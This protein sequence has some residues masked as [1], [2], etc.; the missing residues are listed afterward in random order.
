M[1]IVPPILIS[2]YRCLYLYGHLC[3]LHF[4]VLHCLKA[5]CCHY[6]NYIVQNITILSSSKCA[7]VQIRNDSKIKFIE[8]CF[9]FV[10]IY[11]TSI[12]WM[13]N[14]WGPHLFVISYMLTPICKIVLLF[15]QTLCSKFEA[16]RELNYVY[17]SIMHLLLEIEASMKISS[18]ENHFH[19]VH[20]LIKF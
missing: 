3:I 12:M 17:K 16:S 18:Q 2:T 1:W 8:Y 9:I 6:I 4:C 13:E 19:Y 10:E 5:K 20:K 15:H 14:R 7:I 11:F